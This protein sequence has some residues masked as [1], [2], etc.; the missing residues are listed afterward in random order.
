MVIYVLC[1]YIITNLHGLII[2]GNCL[3]VSTDF[4]KSMNSKVKL[5]M[6]MTTLVEA[7]LGPAKLDEL[8]SIILMLARAKGCAEKGDSYYWNLFTDELENLNKGVVLDV[9]GEKI[10]YV[11]Q[12]GLITA[13][14]PAIK[15]LVDLSTSINWVE[16]I[17][18]L[19]YYAL[20]CCYLFLYFIITCV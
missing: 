5:A 1:I 3:N 18:C 6:F 16:V 12:V 4:V 14:S 15:R 7:E 2:A 9:N 20:L 8:S 10:F 17:Y 13:D 19:L 11:L